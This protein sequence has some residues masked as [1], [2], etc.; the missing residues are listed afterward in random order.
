[1]KADKLE[2]ADRIALQIVYKKVD[3][4][5]LKKYREDY[6]LDLIKRRIVSILI[7]SGLLMFVV[8]LVITRINNIKTYNNLPGVIGN[9]TLLPIFTGLIIYSE[10]T[11]FDNFS[12]S[13]VI[14]IVSITAILG[15]TIS[16]LVIILGT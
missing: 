8:F 7:I 9:I 11:K 13:I 14:K 6:M 10:K 2:R 4:P 1:M 15:A 16:G 5:Y 12:L 3:V